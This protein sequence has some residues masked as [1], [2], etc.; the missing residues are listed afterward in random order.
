MG[1][2]VIVKDWGDFQDKKKYEMELS[3]GKIL[4]E[5]YNWA[6]IVQSRCA[7]LLE[8]Y[9]ERLTAVITATHNSNMY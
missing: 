7:K 3:K 2:L 9:P 1:M 6:S 8:T 5:H 4:E